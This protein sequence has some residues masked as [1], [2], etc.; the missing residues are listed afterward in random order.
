MS[1][2][3]IDL[4]T[5][6]FK[7][8]PLFAES[9]ALL[10]A[11]NLNNHNSMTISWGSFG[12]L[13]HNPV[14]TVFVRPQRFTKTFLDDGNVFTLNFFDDEFKPALQFCGTNSG[15]DV[16]KDLKTRLVAKNFDEGVGYDQAKLVFVCKKQFVSAMK[17]SQFVDKSLVKNFYANGDFHYV[18]VG[19]IEAV[20]KKR[21]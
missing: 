13:W 8:F 21:Y 6:S 12:V 1:F 7:P 10:V 15:R 16:D 3:K 4:K 11:G 17:E 20:F 14:A 9:W 5:Y 18:Y 2:E 19:K